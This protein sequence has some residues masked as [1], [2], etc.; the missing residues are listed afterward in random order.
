MYVSLC[1]SHPLFQPSSDRYPVVAL[2]TS[3]MT[4]SRMR[5]YSFFAGVRYDNTYGNMYI[6][7]TSIEISS[8]IL[9]SSVHYA[10]PV[11]EVVTFTLVFLCERCRLGGRWRQGKNNTPCKYYTEPRSS[12]ASSPDK[13]IYHP[14]LLKIFNSSYQDL[15]WFGINNRCPCLSS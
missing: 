3:H 2:N 13:L 11:H 6:Q 1:L 10:R 15:T 5:C 8:Q 7:G 9:Y 14:T 12:G 4:T